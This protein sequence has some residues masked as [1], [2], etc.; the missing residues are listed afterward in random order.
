MFETDREGVVRD[1]SKEVVRDGSRGAPAASRPP[2]PRAGEAEERVGEEGWS[3]GFLDP[4][5]APVPPAPA[6]P[7]WRPRLWP[8]RERTTEEDCGG[9]G[10]EVR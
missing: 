7:I 2:L 5:P 4:R 3:K 8:G 9:R 6:P 10:G 1:G